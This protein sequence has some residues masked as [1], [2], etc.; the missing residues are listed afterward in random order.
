[1]VLLNKPAVFAATVGPG[2]FGIGIG[3]PPPSE[4][5]IL[6][7]G[8]NIEALLDRVTPGGVAS[9]YFFLGSPNQLNLRGGR[10]E[11]VVKYANLEL[12]A[13]LFEYREK[14]KNRDQHAWDSQQTAKEQHRKV[15]KQLEAST[16]ELKAAAQKRMQARKER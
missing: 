10:N 1:M 16:K 3:D 7:N 2:F 13:Y 12:P 15:M 8:K 9:H 11:V 6:V 5:T 4:P 14:D